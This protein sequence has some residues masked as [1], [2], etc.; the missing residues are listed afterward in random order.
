M[1]MLDLETVDQHG[2]LPERRIKDPTSAAG[3]HS[4]LEKE[5]YNAAIQRACIQGMLDGDPPYS[6][7]E[8]KNL[9][10]A[11]RCNL[12]F[13][14][15]EAIVQ[16]AMSA[17]LD[18]P[19]S[20]D[21]MFHCRTPYGSEEVREEWSQIISEEFTRTLKQWN[22]LEYNLQML[23]KGFVVH[24]V[25]FPYFDNPHN[26]KWA[27]AH[28]GDLKL[29][30]NTPANEEAIEVATIERDMPIHLLYDKIRNEKA[31]TDEGWNVKAVKE[32]LY[33]AGNG[34]GDEYDWNDVERYQRELK[35]NGMYHSFSQGTN[36]RIVYMWVQEFSGKVS[37]SI[38][39]KNVMTDKYLF[40]RCDYYDNIYQALIGFTYGI[41]SGT[42][43]TIRG[44]GYNIFPHVQV[45]NRQLCDV[46][47]MQRLTN[48][49]LVQPENGKELMEV[50]L[51]YIGPVSIL[52]PGFKP[53][54]G[55][56][57]NRMDEALPLIREIEMRVQNNTGTYKPRATTPQ[58]QARTATEVRAQMLQENILSQDAMNLFYT[59]FG[60]LG[61]EMYRRM[62]SKAITAE[63]AGGKEAWEFRERCVKRGVPIEALRAVKTLEPV[64]AVG[65]GSPAMRQQSFQDLLNLAPSLDEVGRV[66]LMRDIVAS[67][68]GGYDRVSRYIR[69]NRT[70]RNATTDE[71]IVSLENV[72]LQQAVTPQVITGQ[73]HV[74]HAKG[75]F[76]IAVPL[77][78][79]VQDHPDKIDAQKT[80]QVLNAIGGHGL[81][82]LSEFAG[83]PSRAQI[84]SKLR[85]AYENL[86]HVAQQLD[87]AVKKQQA[88]A[89]KDAAAQQE[90]AASAGPAA[91]PMQLT[92]ELQ[93]MMQEHM[94]EMK[95]KSE[96]HQQK[97]QI[98]A[99][100]A[101]QKLQ[102]RDAAQ[103]QAIR[104]KGGVNL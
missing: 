28:L 53:V 51:T 49:L 85:P 29:P 52:R 70:V 72:L 62:M 18:L 25:A 5:D 38:F 15:G 3:V 33:V 24:G 103:A 45:M 36:V 82:H 77:I 50:P 83:D 4:F 73:N 37:F 94:V 21:C 99:A 102:L 84:Y 34:N 68:L 7:S 17:F 81:H 46:M 100:D 13:R 48:S 39:A 74:M 64:R 19:N 67:Q 54:T 2:V 11:D 86:M 1:S 104:Q 75:H 78:S 91:G 63:D 32:A 30:R 22:E 12:N 60:R 79:L 43:H 57:P 66:N 31:A 87:N 65:N 27:V 16:A 59:P 88:A 14:D 55:Q 35:E 95:I 58:G 56:L 69:G 71:E 44:L 26:W 47:D 10:Q 41:G 42:Y 20:V 92:P 23:S 97:M 96:D 80:A 9:G 61:T 101:N 6:E 98:R 93:S 76:A 90:A 89:A 8:L 40:D